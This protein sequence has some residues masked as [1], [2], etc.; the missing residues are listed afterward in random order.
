MLPP[1]QGIA[2]LAWAFGKLRIEPRPELLQAVMTRTLETAHLFEPQNISNFM[3]GFANLA[4]VDFDTIVPEN[5]A[6]YISV[7]VIKA[8]QDQAMSV[9]SD[10]KAQ[11]VASFNWALAAMRVR[12]GEG[13]GLAFQNVILEKTEDFSPHELATLTVRTCQSSLS[14]D[15]L[16]MHDH[17]RIGLN[18]A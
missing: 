8:L 9:I 15:T 4:P 3:L 12:L 14:C 16:S 11:E 5:T 10:F 18:P 13:L 6:R 7:E 1:L 2:N 17:A